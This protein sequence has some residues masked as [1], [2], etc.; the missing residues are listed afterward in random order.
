VPDAK[1]C[2]VTKKTSVVLDCSISTQAPTMDPTTSKDDVKRTPV[3]RPGLPD[4]LF[5]V[6]NPF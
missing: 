5:I 6:I 3:L 1:F 4:W 2:L